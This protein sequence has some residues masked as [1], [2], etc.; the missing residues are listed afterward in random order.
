MR[1]TGVEKTAI[2]I[3]IVNVI[4]FFVVIGLLIWGAIALV[5]GINEKGLKGVVS[6]I[7]EG[8]STNVIVEV[9]ETNAVD[10]S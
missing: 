9:V 2:G 8:T 5:C 10:N 4:L 7:W 6:S 3:I 1:G